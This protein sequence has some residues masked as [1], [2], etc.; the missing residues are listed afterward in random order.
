VMRFL[1]SPDILSHVLWDCIHR[2][3]LGR[4]HRHVL[5]WRIMLEDSNYISRVV[6]LW[7]VIRTLILYA[8]IARFYFMCLLSVV[9][10]VICAR[11]RKISWFIRTM[12]KI[13]V[14]TFLGLE[15]ILPIISCVISRYSHPDH[16]C[17][18]LW[19]TEGQVI[20]GRKPSRAADKNHMSTWEHPRKLWKKL[21]N[22]RAATLDKRLNELCRKNRRVFWIKKKKRSEMV[23]STRTQK[24]DR[25]YVEDSVYTIG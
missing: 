10:I 7:C 22:S 17:G 18:L 9:A 16:T 24:L 15:H 12:T 25:D 19:L 14:V 4:H 8:K 3:S 6:S 1:L 11:R 2:W 5:T 20:E 13:Y 21:E 23:L